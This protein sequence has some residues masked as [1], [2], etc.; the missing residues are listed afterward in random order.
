MK[1]TKNIF[2]VLIILLAACKK[3]N[4]YSSTNPTITYKYTTNVSN[5]YIMEYTNANGGRDT[6][7]VTGAAWSTSFITSKSQGFTY[8]EVSLIENSSPG[9]DVQGNLEIDVNGVSKA[10]AP[11]NIQTDGD[12]GNVLINYTVF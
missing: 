5:T 11:I 2:I 12:G 9:P 3:E 8:A 10:S 1:Y 4:K 6:V 7:K